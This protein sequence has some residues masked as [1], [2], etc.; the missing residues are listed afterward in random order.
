MPYLSRRRRAQAQAGHAAQ[1]A[2]GAAE[3]ATAG[4]VESRRVVVTPSD[5]LTHETPQPKRGLHDRHDTSA[6]PSPK[7]GGSGSY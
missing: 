2:A 4:A 1:R 6:K 3:T 7:R 5:S